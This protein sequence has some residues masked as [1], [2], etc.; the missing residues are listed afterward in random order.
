MTT[1]VPSKAKEPTTMEELLARTGFQIRSFTRGQKVE[2]KLIRIADRAA[3]FDVGGKSEGI[4]ANADFDEA[5]DYIKTLKEGDS[6]TATVIAPEANDGSILLS[7]RSTMS[8]SL[9]EK[10]EEVKKEQKALN[11]TGKHASDAGVTVEVDS[12]NGF[13]PMSQIGRKAAKNPEGFVGK[14]FAVKVIE[15]DK[16]R[17]RIVFSEKA[18]SEEAEM[19]SIEEAIKDAKEG[20]V[21]DG[22]VTTVSKF[23]AFVKIEIDA[24]GKKIPVEGLVHVSEISWDKV[25]SPS[26]RLSEGDKVK[27]KMLGTRDGKLSLSIKQAQKDPWGD[28][29][30]KYQKDAKVK[31]KIVRTSDFGVFVELE[32]GVEGL[33]HITK[34]PHETKLNVGDSVNVY[35]EEVDARNRK[36]SLGM[37]LTAKP[38]GYK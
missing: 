10:F 21:Y 3:F 32:P 35:V 18:V 34:I 7:L 15:V 37:V 26:D 38:V 4:V 13:I 14:V 24:K 23:G 29:E 31:G 19:K 17:A 1:K 36:V 6:V 25:E 9:W 33:L 11:V 30:K 16:R 27:V 22:I 2:A 5:K 8:D 20:E 12:V 28:V